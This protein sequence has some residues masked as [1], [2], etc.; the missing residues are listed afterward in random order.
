MKKGLRR[1]VEANGLDDLGTD[2]DLMKKG[3]RL[4]CC[5]SVFFF[6]ANGPRPYEEG[7]KTRFAFYLGDVAGTDPDLMKK[8]LRL[9]KRNLL[10]LHARNG[11]RPYEEGIKTPPAP[12]R[13][14]LRVERTQTL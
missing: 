3:L 11:P 5:Q 4:Y 1:V 10:F 12:S 14:S 8:G 9:R 6:T 7:I 13:Y 2:P